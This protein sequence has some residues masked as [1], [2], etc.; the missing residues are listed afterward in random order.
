[1]LLC[2]SC[3][4]CAVRKLTRS[5]K[6]S[7]HEILGAQHL[8]LIYEK[9]NFSRCPKEKVS[10]LWHLVISGAQPCMFYRDP[11]FYLQSTSITSKLI[12]VVEPSGV[13]SRLERYISGSNFHDKILQFKVLY[14]LMDQP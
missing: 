12:A 10:R 11:T 7:N 4:G 5:P 2:R 14:P 6:V 1:M 8:S 9:S 13:Y 3:Q